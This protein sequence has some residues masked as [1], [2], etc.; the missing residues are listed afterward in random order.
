MLLSAML[1]D[2]ILWYIESQMNRTL[3]MIR[4]VRKQQ[5]SAA[6][7]RTSLPLSKLNCTAQCIPILPSPLHL[8]VCM[9]VLFLVRIRTQRLNRVMDKIIGNVYTYRHNSCFMIRYGD[10]FCE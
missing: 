7:R 4:Y 3:S 6:R 1:L 8:H 9:A 2:S 10:D 5:N